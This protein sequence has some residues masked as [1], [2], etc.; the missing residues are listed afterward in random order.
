MLNITYKQLNR[1]L[2]RFNFGSHFVFYQL[3][4]YILNT[5]FVGLNLLFFCLCNVKQYTTTYIIKNI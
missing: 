3:S 1:R 5:L 4:T 2:S